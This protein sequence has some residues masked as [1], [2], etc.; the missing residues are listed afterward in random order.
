M[1]IFGVPIIICG[2]DTK[3]LNAELTHSIKADTICHIHI[4]KDIVKTITDHR[5]DGTA[6]TIIIEDGTMIGNCQEEEAVTIVIERTAVTIEKVEEIISNPDAKWRYKQQK[7]T[8]TTAMSRMIVRMT[9]W[10]RI[11]IIRTTSMMNNTSSCPL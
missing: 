3:H 1:N 6:G 10:S 11:M 8:L 2:N 4:K 5:T 9:Q 7:M